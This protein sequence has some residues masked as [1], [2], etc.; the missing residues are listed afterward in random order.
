MPY[1]EG[2]SNQHSSLSS[3]QQYQ[4]PQTS[5]SSKK[6]WIR[7]RKP[8]FSKREA[9][10]AAERRDQERLGG[11]GEKLK[12]GVAGGGSGDGNSDH[13]NSG[14]SGSFG[15]S[16]GDMYSV[17]NSSDISISDRLS[18]TGT[19]NNSTTGGL[20]TTDQHYY[21]YNNSNSGRNNVDDALSMPD[22]E[23]VGDGGEELL[24]LTTPLAN[25]Q[26]SPGDP[27][28]LTLG[29]LGAGLETASVVWFGPLGELSQDT[30]YEQQHLRDGTIAL[31]LHSCT[32]NDTGRYTCVV[33]C[34]GSANT[35][36]LRCSASV[37]FAGGT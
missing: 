35:R 13:R 33:T 36:Q 14:G 25:V 23:W 21:Y 15:G 17:S 22:V 9:K 20:S 34:V 12:L 32:P 10:A 11:G 7:F 18:F 3:N 29:V 37:I 19:D 31:H 5:S 28:T 30:R 1:S 8:S 6:S 27:F 4:P 16:Y 24:R 26:L 2:S